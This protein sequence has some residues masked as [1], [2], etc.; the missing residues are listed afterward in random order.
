MVRK[1]IRESRGGCKAGFYDPKPLLPSPIPP[2]RL[3]KLEQE[4]REITI[5][6]FLVHTVCSLLVAVEDT[7]FHV[8]LAVMTIRKEA[9]FLLSFLVFFS[10][11][12]LVIGKMQLFPSSVIVLSFKSELW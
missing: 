2:V 8:V 12:S 1:G 11:P 3:L 4:L 6:C 9:H 10:H 5:S 7:R